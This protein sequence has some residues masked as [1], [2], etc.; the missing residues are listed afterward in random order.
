VP[1]LLRRKVLQVLVR[2]R[3]ECSNRSRTTT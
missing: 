3:Y 2:T 1:Q